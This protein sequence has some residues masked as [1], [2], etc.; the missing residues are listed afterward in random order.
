M[1]TA[2]RVKR[3]LSKALIVDDSLV[4]D[5]ALL[6]ED[7]GITSLDRFELLVDLEAEFGMEINEEDLE[8]VK[9]VADV[10]RRI[11][12]KTAPQEHKS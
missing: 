6:A 4:V 11:E 8:G 1:D 12:R 9:T 7:L 5:N 3:V 2:S 10:V